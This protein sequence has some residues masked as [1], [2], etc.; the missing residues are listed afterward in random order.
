MEDQIQSSILF[1]PAAV[2]TLANGNCLYDIELFLKT[3]SLWNTSPPPVYLYCTKKITEAL[4]GFKYPGKIH[5]NQSLEP[6]EGLTRP[7]MEK[8]ESKK[9]YQTLWHDFMLEKCSLLQWVFKN[10]SAQ[11]M[12]RGILF[13]DADICWFGPIPTIPAGK[14]IALSHHYIRKTDELKFGTYNGGFLWTNDA[15]MPTK[16]IEAT[17][18][19]R[20]VEQAAL[21]DLPLKYNE[22]QLFKFGQEVNYGWWRMFQSDNSPQEKQAEWT[23]KRDPQQAHSGLLVRGAPLVCIHTHF[24][25]ED[26]VT[27]LFNTFMK[28]KLQ[29]LKSQEKIKKLLK[30]II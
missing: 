20:F 4:P 2:C 25:T 22:D 21:E 27:N 29:I 26:H 11:N 24:K 8:M 18:T 13:C 5:V 17:K 30:W 9:G 16:W 23:I 12:Q 19:S 3:L 6:Y 15:E 28:N 7:M 14:R 1:E 10:I